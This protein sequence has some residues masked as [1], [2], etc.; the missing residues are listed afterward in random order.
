MNTDGVKEA[1][2]FDFARLFSSPLERKQLHFSSIGQ[3]IT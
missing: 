2:V 3:L 1:I